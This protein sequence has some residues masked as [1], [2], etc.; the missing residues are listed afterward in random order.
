M[1]PDTVQ[2]RLLPRQIDRL[3]I[4]QHKS[5]N[6]H[7]RFHGNLNRRRKPLVGYDQVFRACGIHINALRI[8]RIILNLFSDGAGAVS[9]LNPEIAQIQF[10]AKGILCHG[11][12]DFEMHLLRELHALILIL[13]QISIRDTLSCRHLP[14]SIR[15]EDIDLYIARRLDLYQIIHAQH[16]IRILYINQ[17]K[18]A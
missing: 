10:A 5:A 17:I 13:W 4:F 6:D 16:E 15:H 7:L 2:I 11:L 1:K 3:G 12:F 8:C 14:G 9:P 18:G